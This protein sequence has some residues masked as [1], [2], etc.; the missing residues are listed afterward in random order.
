MAARMRRL[1]VDDPQAFAALLVAE[2][3]NVA[4]LGIMNGYGQV[5]FAS[6]E[7]PAH[8]RMAP[9]YLPAVTRRLH[10]VVVLTASDEVTK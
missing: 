9:S 8:P 6:D 2:G 10:E 5:F 1:P 7:A 3:A 4:T